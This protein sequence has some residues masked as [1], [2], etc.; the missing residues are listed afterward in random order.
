MMIHF[1]YY[2]NTGSEKKATMKRE[3]HWFLLDP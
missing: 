1:N 3:G 2:Y